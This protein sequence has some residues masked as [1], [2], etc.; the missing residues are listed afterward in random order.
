M[1]PEEF[2]L[3]AGLNFKDSHLLRRALTHRSF[4]NENPEVLEDN[5]RLEYLGDAALDFLTAAWL[6][7]HFPEMNE[8]QLTRLRS[9]LVRTE[10]L[11]AFAEE[12]HLGEALL[13]GRGEDSTG[14]RGR[15]ALLCAAFEA[16]IGALYLDAGLEAVIEFME[17]RLE[18]ASDAVLDDR[19]LFDARSLLQIWAQAELGETPRYHTVDSYGPDHAREFVVEVT[20][21]NGIRGRGRGRSKQD[22]AQ[23]AA[24]DAMAQVDQTAFWE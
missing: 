22:A 9:A 21:G 23:E 4:V 6:Y 3:Q 12:I 18:A 11:A 24:V 16:L 15:P 2:A 8:G 10:Q 14:G 5:E 13:L 17:P 1:S 19:S 7:K 20:V